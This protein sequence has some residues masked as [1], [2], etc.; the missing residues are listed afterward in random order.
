MS[1][2]IALTIKDRVL[3]AKLLPSRGD[4]LSMRIK[5]EICK[6]IEISAELM[7]KLNFRADSDGINWDTK[8]KTGEDIPEASKAILVE[9][10]NAE[11]SL[12][13]SHIDTL[14]KQKAISVELLSLI[15]K[16]KGIS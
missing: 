10:S 9:F 8:T 4:I 11:I 6:K 3:I 5:Q 13:E 12:F 1:K 16:I 2:K 7:S 15:D 14:D